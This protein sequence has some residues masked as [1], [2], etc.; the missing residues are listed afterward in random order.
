MPRLSQ[1]KQIPY[2]TV[3]LLWARGKTVS[4]I[5]N[6][7]GWTKPRSK[8]PYSY[9]YGVLKRLRKGSLSASSRSASMK[10]EKRRLQASD[11]AFA[12]FAC[13]SWFVRTPKSDPLAVVPG[14][15]SLRLSE[16]NGALFPSISCDKLVALA[17]SS[18]HA[19]EIYKLLA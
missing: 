9:T 13:E 1:K 7:M 3:A 5:S 17:K 8:F 12:L 14:A 2:A 19:E 4:E 15:C 6:A 10:R 11:L 16:A 18:I